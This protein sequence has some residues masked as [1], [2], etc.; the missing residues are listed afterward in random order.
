MYVCGVQ[1]RLCTAKRVICCHLICAAL[2]I[3]GVAIF[4]CVRVFSRPVRPPR[5]TSN[6]KTLSNGTHSF[7]P[8]VLIISLDG[9]RPDYIDIGVTPHIHRLR[10]EGVAPEYV[11][12]S[13]PSVTFPNVP[14][15]TPNAQSNNIALHL[16]DRIVSREPRRY[17]KVTPLGLWIP[18]V[19]EYWDPVQEKEFNI[20]RADQSLQSVWWEGT[21]GGLVEPIWV[22]AEKQGLITAI[23]MWPGSEAVIHGI[24]PTHVDKF[25]QHELLSNKVDRVMSWFDLDDSERPAFIATY[26]PTIDVYSL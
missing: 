12:P 17:W 7:Q 6:V 11:K 4:L 20:R 14:N 1:R 13:F 9:F 25:N 8:T 18:N 23:H 26:V 15:S 21:S 10:E 24:Q 3:I 2:I 22:T 5:R 16:G 19:S